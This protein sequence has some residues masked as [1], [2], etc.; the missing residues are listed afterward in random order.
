MKLLIL[1]GPPSVGKTTVGKIIE[2][3]TDFKLFHNHMV[4][5]GVM[6]L[7]G[8]GTP[9]EDRLSREIRSRIIEEAAIAG[10]NLVFTYVWNFGIEK[11]KNNIDHYKEMYESRGGEVLFVEL[12]AALPT[13]VHRAKSPER[14]ELKK[15]APD[16]E[17]V[18]LLDATKNFTSPHPFF[19]PDAYTKIDT[20][21]KTPEAIADEII[22]I[23]TEENRA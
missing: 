14:A 1:F 11:G 16:S 9:A 3:K 17:R 12:G 22:E 20:E 5:D 19:Y 21:E 18:A 23:V 10:M 13:R 15:Y 2:S 6:H 8:V 4:M 7:F